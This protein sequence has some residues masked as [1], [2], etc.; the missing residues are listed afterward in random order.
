[1]IGLMYLVSSKQI[2]VGQLQFV[3]KV[4]PITGDESPELVSEV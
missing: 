3:A 2:I 4:Q 1:M